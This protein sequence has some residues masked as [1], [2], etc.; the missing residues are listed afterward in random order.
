M[1][2]DLAGGEWRLALPA[3]LPLI[4]ANGR[5]HF[6]SRRRV[7]SALRSAAALA[8]RQ[9]RGLAAALAA[10]R[11]RPLVS[12]AHIIGILHPASRR[13]VDPANFY[14][15][16]KAAVDGLVDAGVLE[17]DDHTRVIGPDMRLG[18][19]VRGAQLALVI[20]PLSPA[21]YEEL[22]ASQHVPP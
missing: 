14:P 6:H 5:E 7:T 22:L 10:A 18:P 13:R 4:N 15:A 3:G 11:G 17:D 12:R 8:V 21:G 16:F 1:S 2:G 9:D 20:R 19:V